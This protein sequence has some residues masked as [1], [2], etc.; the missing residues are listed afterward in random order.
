MYTVQYMYTCHQ[1]PCLYCCGGDSQDVE[2]DCAGDYGE[3]I[4]GAGSRDESHVREGGRHRHPEPVRQPIQHD[5]AGGN[6]LRL[7]L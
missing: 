1:C 2:H 6:L 5:S 3:R 7:E 4:E